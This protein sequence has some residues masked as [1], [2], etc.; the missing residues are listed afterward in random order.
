MRIFKVISENKKGLVSST[1]IIDK[2]IQTVRR[3][4]KK[5]KEQEISIRELK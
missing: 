5:L 4:L 3:V 1:I 2:D